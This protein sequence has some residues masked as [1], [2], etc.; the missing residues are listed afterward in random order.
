MVSSLTAV[1]LPV[2]VANENLSFALNPSSPHPHNGNLPIHLLS[3]YPYVP[4]L[5]PGVKVAPSH[6]TDPSPPFWAINHPIGTVVL[7]SARASFAFFLL[8]PQKPY[9]LLPHPNKWPATNAPARDLPALLRCFVPASG[10]T[11]IFPINA[12]S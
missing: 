6:A 3:F 7:Q 4:R 12:A 1:S 9:P 5:D 2:R 8:K 11:F 10:K